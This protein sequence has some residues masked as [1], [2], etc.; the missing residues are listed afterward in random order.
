MYIRS[1]NCRQT[2]IRLAMRRLGDHPSEASL[3]FSIANEAIFLF[4]S[5]RGALSR[6]YTLADIE[7]ETHTRS[8]PQPH[9]MQRWIYFPLIKLLLVYSRG[10]P[11]RSLS[12]PARSVCVSCNSPTCASRCLPAAKSCAAICRTNRSRKCGLAL[13]C[14]TLCYRSA[15]YTD[16]KFNSNVT[17]RILYYLKLINI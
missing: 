1:H 6:I 5:I 2:Q 15:V 9:H 14:V 12:L 3:A 16:I 8:A 11:I 13:D 7:R 17:L 10:A 4:S